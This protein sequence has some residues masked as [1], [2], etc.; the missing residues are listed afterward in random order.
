M[1]LT[2]CCH[3]SLRWLVGRITTISWAPQLHMLRRNLGVV[4][5]RH[6]SAPRGGP[7]SPVPPTEHPLPCLEQDMVQ[8]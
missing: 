8:P 5:R 1:L 7:E 6:A 4:T 2:I 3:G